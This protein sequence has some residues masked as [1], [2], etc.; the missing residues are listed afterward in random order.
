M[1]TTRRSRRVYHFPHHYVSALSVLEWR[2]IN[3]FTFAIYLFILLVS[4]IF[5]AFMLSPVLARG[6]IRPFVRYQIV[7]G[8]FWKQMKYFDANW[9]NWCMGQGHQTVK[10]GHQEVKSSSQDAESSRNPFGEISQELTIWRICPNTKSGFSSFNIY[11][12][13]YLVGHQFIR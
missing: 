5:M 9:R 11:L 4:V 7:N 8:M 1:L 3:L 13:I 10:F 12:V 2:Y 6:T